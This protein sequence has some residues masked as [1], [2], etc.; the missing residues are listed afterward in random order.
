MALHIEIG[1]GETIRVGDALI[2]IEE[3]KGRSKSRLRIEADRSV[4]VEIVKNDDVLFYWLD[5]I[6]FDFQDDCYVKDNLKN[7]F[8]I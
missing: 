7:S 2:S 8:K 4:R 6:W 5:S 1:E 3:K